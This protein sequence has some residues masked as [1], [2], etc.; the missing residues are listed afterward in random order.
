V[1]DPTVALRFTST[2]RGVADD[3]N[4]MTRATRT[5]TDSVDSS[6]SRVNRASGAMR[7]GIRGATMAA[8]ASIFSF[9]QSSAGD[10]LNMQRNL[11][12]LDTKARTVFADQLPR[13]QKWADANRKAFGESS[14]NVVAMAASMT[15]LLKPMGFTASQASNMSMKL[16]D[17]S[18][19]LSRWSGG[20]K[21]AAEV[22][23]ILSAALLGERDSLQSLGI[24]ISQAEI[25]SRLAAKG[26]KELTGATKQQAEAIATQELI[27]E[28]STDAQKAW[29][30]GGKEAAEKQNA[31]SSNI[32]QSM[33]S[34]AVAAAPLIE[35]LTM[36][37]TT[38]MDWAANH[39]TAVIAIAAVTAGIWALNVALAANPIVLV[40]SLIALLV[41]ALIWLWNNSAGF[42]NFFIGIWDD[43]RNQVAGF[44]SWI[45][46]AWNGLMTFFRNIGNGIAGIFNGVGSAISSAFRGAV[47]VVVSILNGAIWAVNKLIDGINHVPGVNIPH[48][49]NVPKMHTG[50]LV[51]GTP[52]SDQL[53]ILQEGEQVL[54]RGSSAGSG[55]GGGTVLALRDGNTAG[56]ADF[57]S[58]MFRNGAVQLIT[59]V[60]GE[61]VRVV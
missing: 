50:G 57:V 21:T 9:V 17:L 45:T 38:I 36:V 4:Q 26:Q 61:A 6:S 14:R 24:S 19:A 35:F 47:N 25:D 20:T 40:V 22:S 54:P 2:S 18:G 11:D 48:I 34:L 12:A 10:F 44:V 15:D 33:E 51:G 49:P 31:A 32:K 3:I 7:D 8:G 43:I 30:D 1:S 29:A 16:L 37:F 46:G 39:Q 58:E 59:S 60:S 56:A 52:G 13:V 23:D 53:R 27:L 42:R 5:M 55:G 28:K 41:G